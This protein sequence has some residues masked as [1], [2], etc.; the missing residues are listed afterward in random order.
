[1]C[2]STSW[3]EFPVTSLRVVILKLF[4]NDSNIEQVLSL[5]FKEKLFQEIFAHYY[6]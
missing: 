5:V 3:F 4:L 2:M 6:V 1:M